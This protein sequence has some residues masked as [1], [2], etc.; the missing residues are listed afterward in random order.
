MRETGK[1]TAIPSHLRSCHS[2]CRVEDF[3]THYGNVESGLDSLGSC[4]E[5]PE[6]GVC[7]NMK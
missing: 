3:G 7:H 2:C 4:A 1:T 5:I 6:E